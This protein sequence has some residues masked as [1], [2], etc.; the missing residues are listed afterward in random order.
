MHAATALTPSKL[1]FPRPSGLSVQPSATERLRLAAAELF[2]QGRLAE[3][4]ALIHDALQQHPDSEDVLVMRA[5][6]SEV[7]HDWSSAAAALEHLVQLQGRSAP[8][9]VWC[10]WVRVLRCQGRSQRA[11]EVAAQALTWHPLHP[12]LSAEL[13]ALGQPVISEE[14]RAA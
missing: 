13:M 4:D 14:R 10:H 1:D 3:A 9:E 11:G 6:I 7:L 5:L 12:A 2:R 8:A